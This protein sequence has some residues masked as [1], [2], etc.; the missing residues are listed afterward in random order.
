[1]ADQRLLPVQLCVG[2]EYSWYYVPF[3]FDYIVLKVFQVEGLVQ[4]KN[5]YI[6]DGK[7]FYKTKNGVIHIPTTNEYPQ[8][9]IEK[10]LL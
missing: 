7:A 6:R 4:F 9:L 1:M 3:S 8:D 2:E 5:G 10:G